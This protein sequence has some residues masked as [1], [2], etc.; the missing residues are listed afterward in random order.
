MQINYTGTAVVFRPGHLFGGSISFDAP[1]AR[2]ISYYLEPILAMA[3]FCK[4]PLKITINGVVNNDMD[5]SIDNL[6][7]KIP[8]FYVS[9]QRFFP[10]TRHSASMAKQTSRSSN[11][12]THLS[13]KAPCS[14]H[15]QLSRTS[16][17]WNSLIWA[18]LNALEELHMLPECHL[19]W[20]TG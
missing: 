8:L 16:N 11:A 20:L 18:V 6:V 19:K 3:P 7:K 10:F 9:G 17:Q 4:E 5:A 14:S 2:A 13:A 1:T 12:A 15:A